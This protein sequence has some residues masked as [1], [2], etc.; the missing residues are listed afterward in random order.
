MTRFVVEK[1]L[2]GKVIMEQPSFKL[3]VTVIL[4]L[5]CCCRQ[6]K[7]MVAFNKLYPVIYACR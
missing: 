4:L 2:A 6:I 3:C 1:H 7:G 5:L